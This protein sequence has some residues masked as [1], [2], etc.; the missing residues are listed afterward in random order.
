MLWP[1]DEIVP[2]S[3][4][5]LRAFAADADGLLVVYASVDR[6][7]L[8]AAPN[9]K[10][11][12]LPHAGFG[13]VDVEASRNSSVIVTD[14]PNV[15]FET[16]ADTTF[17]LIFSARRLLIGANDDLRS[18]KWRRT[19]FD[20]HLGLD[21]SGAI[22]GLAGFGQIARA[23]ARSTAGKSTRPASTCSTR[24]HSAIRRHLSCST[25]ASPPF[26]TSD[27]RRMPPVSAWRTLLWTIF[28]PCSAARAR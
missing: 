17:A 23:V 13:S 21:V 27:Q 25:C 11:V 9:L 16:T 10:I 4:E 19:R 3:A 14:T 20:E 12:A 26:L 6:A 15:L 5:A 24:S 7:F 18:G 28:W 22:L 2:A 1:D 8:E